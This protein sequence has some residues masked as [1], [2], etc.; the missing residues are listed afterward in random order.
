MPKWVIRTQSPQQLDGLR[1]Q[2]NNQVP[3]VQVQPATIYQYPATF[4]F[5][6]RILTF[7]CLIFRIIVQYRPDY[8]R[9]FIRDR[10]G[11]FIKP[12]PFFQRVNP[13]IQIAIIIIR[14]NPDNSAGT[15]NKKSPQMLVAF[16]RHIHQHLSVTTGVLARNQTKPGCKVTTIFKFSSFANRGNNCSGRFRADDFYF[17]SQFFKLTLPI[18]CSSGC[19]NTNQAGRNISYRLE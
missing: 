7:N 9:V 17:M 12:S 11:H 8:S 2:Y 1:G 3:I 19:F 14:G 4:N 16:F 18:K 13:L 15:M 6:G 5:S 10:H